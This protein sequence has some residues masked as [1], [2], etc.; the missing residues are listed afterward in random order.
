MLA[1]RGALPYNASHLRV[2]AETM[3]SRPG[4]NLW[5]IGLWVTA[6]LGGLLLS[7]PVCAADA[8]LTDIVLTNT[9]DHVVVYFR[10]EDCFTKEMEEA[11][12]NGIPTTFTFFVKLHEMRKLWWDKSI[13]DLKVSHEIQ[14]D[15]L[16]KEY[17][18]RLSEEDDEIHTVADFEEAKKMMSEIVAL[19]ITEL[20]NLQKGERYQ[21]QMMA[22]L[23]TIKLPFSLHY[24]F[25]FL[26]LWDFETDWFS[27]D[28]RYF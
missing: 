15:G 1:L 14:Y 16:K 24:V 4:K 6:F 12:H 11:I 28:F 2:F 8:R 13:A 21:V 9:R 7:G 27:V 5:K 25:F 23:D 3:N 26:S 19:K 18:L 20:S 10:V 22:E 17:R